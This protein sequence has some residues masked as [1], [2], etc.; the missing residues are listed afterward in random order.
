M[1]IL[2]D[3]GLKAI[4]I[5]LFLALIHVFDNISFKLLISYLENKNWWF[6]KI[7]TLLYMINISI[8]KIDSFGHLLYSLTIFL[9]AMSPYWIITFKLYYSSALCYSFTYLS[10]Y[11]SSTQKKFLPPQLA[12]LSFLAY[13]RNGDFKT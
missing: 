5:I 7:M 3:F 8:S 6:F 12:Y 4:K 2:F 10:L 11:P 9:K 1:L 13:F